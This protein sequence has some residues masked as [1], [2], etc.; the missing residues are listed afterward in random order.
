MSR[1]IIGH[2]SLRAP[3][4][5]D[6]PTLTWWGVFNQR[7]YEVRGHL[8]VAERQAGVAV[9]WDGRLREGGRRRM[10]GSSP[11]L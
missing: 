5:I 8:S 9:A 7:A 3:R 2:G 11:V 1:S 6:S 4:R 10:A